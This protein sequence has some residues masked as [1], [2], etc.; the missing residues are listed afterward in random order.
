VAYRIELTP[1]AE[2]SLAKMAKSDRTFLKRID[3]ALLALTE[4][5]VPTNSKQLV[6]EDP[7]LYRLRVGDYRIL[8][9]VEDDVL[10]FLV[11]QVGHRKDV[12][13]FLKR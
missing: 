1:A 12:Y 3:Q 2:K 11:V 13:R 9:Q 6:G 4:S 7:P 10:V 8:Y 5:P